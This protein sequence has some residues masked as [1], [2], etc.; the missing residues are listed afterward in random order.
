MRCYS[1]SA[2]PGASGAGARCPGAGYQEMEEG[3]SCTVRALS[4]STVVF[5]VEWKRWNYVV[6]FIVFREMFPRLQDAQMKWY[7][8]TIIYQIKH[9][10]LAIASKFVFKDSILLSYLNCYTIRSACCDW[11]LCNLNIETANMTQEQYSSLQNEIISEVWYFK[12]ICN[13]QMI[14]CYFRLTQQLLLL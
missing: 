6:I 4:D 1:C 11:D 14:F 8:I 13:L 10:D 12:G 2:F 7:I 9:L 3:V 5:Q